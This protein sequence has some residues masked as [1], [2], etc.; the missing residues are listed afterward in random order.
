MVT[1]IED[2]WV[3]EAI[4]FI[5]NYIPNIGSILAAIPPT[6][7]AAIQSGIGWAVV[8]A[9]GLF[10]IEQFVGNFLDPI[11]QGHGNSISPVAILLFV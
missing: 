4:I 8:V 7:M 10:L 6:I 5:L 3:W 2:A 1:G 11:L 9:V